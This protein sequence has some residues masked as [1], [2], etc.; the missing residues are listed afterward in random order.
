MKTVKGL[1]VKLQPGKITFT[2][3]NGATVTFKLK[4]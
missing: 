3:A 4:S 2:N 1:S